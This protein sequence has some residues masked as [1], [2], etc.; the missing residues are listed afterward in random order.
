MDAPENTQLPHDLTRNILR[1]P[2]YEPAGTSIELDGEALTRN[3]LLT[4]AIGSGKTSTLNRMLSQLI[5]YRAGEAESKMG[6]LIFDFKNDGTAERVRA[7]AKAVGRGD[8]VVELSAESDTRLELFDNFSSL[9]NLEEVTDS[10]LTAMPPENGDN[11]YFETARRKRV[12]SFLGIYRLITK[13]PLYG[14]DVLEFINACACSGMASGI[15]VSPPEDLARFEAMVEAL[16]NGSLGN[17]PERL[18][19]SIYRLD[20][21]L[22]EWKMLDGRTR[23]NEQS[24]LTNLLQ[25]YTSYAA[26][27]FLGGREKEVVRIEDVVDKGQLIVVTASALRTPHLASTLGRWMKARFFT[28]LHSRQLSYDSSRRMAG[29]ILDEYPLVATGGEQGFSD[30]THLQAMRAMRGFTIA[31]TQ[32]FEALR[33]VLGPDEVAALLAQFDQHFFFQSKEAAVANFT[34]SLWG[35][36]ADWQA[37]PR[38][39]WRPGASDLSLPSLPPMPGAYSAEWKARVGVPELAALQPGEAWVWARGTQGSRKPFWLVP[40]HASG[41][42]AANPAEEKSVLWEAKLREAMNWT[43]DHGP[44]KPPEEGLDDWSDFF[45]SELKRSS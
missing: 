5:A 43:A 25:I 41:T 16:S 40:L 17:V 12:E 38:S 24:T 4:G 32:G 36:V 20:T 9:A 22:C 11:R 45:P 21:S 33:R 15:R 18:E 31:A 3:I 8:D 6:L 29:L 34:E 37:S 44:L 39:H 26:F 10:L 13:G 2:C 19:K 30:L 1:L 27:D 42:T 28:H 35:R 14:P 7:W 23:S